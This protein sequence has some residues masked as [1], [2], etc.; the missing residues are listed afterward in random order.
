[1]PKPGSHPY[2]CTYHT[3]EHNPASVTAS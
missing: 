3:S 2:Y 1:V